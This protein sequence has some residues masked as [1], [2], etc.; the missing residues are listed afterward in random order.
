MGCEHS[1][2]TERGSV[3]FWE[4]GCWW[5]LLISRLQ[6]ISTMVLTQTNPMSGKIFLESREK[7]KP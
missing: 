1:L 7:L 6:F 4:E 5:P 3:S 2:A